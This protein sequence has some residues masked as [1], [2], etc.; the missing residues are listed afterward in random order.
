VLIG[1][2]G[3]G[4]TTVGRLL[5]ARLGWAFV[6]ADDEIEAA[7][8]CS[9]AEIFAREGEPGF[10]EREA[11]VVAELA[12]REKHVISLG[13]GA[14]LREETRSVIRSAG[15][16]VWLTASPE[17]IYSRISGDT[18][19]SARRPNLTVRGGLAEIEEVLAM[20]R[21]FYEACAMR[22]IDTEGRSPEEIAASILNSR[23]S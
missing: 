1:Y 12:Q 17:T 21:P 8:G 3:T 5:A 11:R 23:N 2:R 19:T 13:G 10:R 9:I 16:V 20:R 18:S 14:V 4:K 15:E 7:A 6:D 22:T